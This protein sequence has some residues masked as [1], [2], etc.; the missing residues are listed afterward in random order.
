MQPTILIVITK[1]DVGGAQVHC[2]DIIKGLRLRYRF[3]LLC[4]ED[5]FLTQAAR[6]LG[7]EVIVMPSL[8]RRLSPSKDLAAYRDLKK[9]IS[10]IKP[11]LIHGHSSK[12]GIIARLAAKRSATPAM[13]T[14]HGWAFTQGAPLKR[15]LIGLVSE[16]VMGRFSK[17]I[18]VVSTYDYELARRFFIA[19]KK[20]L[21]C[22]LNGVQGTQ[23]RSK[24]QNR[25]PH[26]INIG[27]LTRVK[28]Q[29]LLLEA[30]AQVSSPFTLSI[31]GSGHLQPQIEDQIKQL[32]LSKKVTLLPGLNNASSCLADSDLFVLSSKYEGLPLSALEA[33]SASLP[34]VSTNVGGVGDA[35]VDG[36]TGFLVVKDNATV[37]A[38]KL[39]ILLQSRD[40]RQQMGEAG[41]RKYQTDFTVER[42]VTELAKVYDE[43]FS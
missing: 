12:A 19:P 6:Q 7:I 30:L 25:V 13:F 42:M 41:Y 35:V 4:G 15:R 28:N 5:D 33:M 22:I 20:R 36:E 1:A 32:G 16:W 26:I 10:R 34:V 8:V 40:L 27:R 9:H 39:E 29:T 21:R 38:E 24:H 18:V 17:F 14:A 43:V 23:K 2:L 31:I 3:V 37:L 11:D